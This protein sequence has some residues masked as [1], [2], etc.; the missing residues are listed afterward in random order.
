MTPKDASLVGDIKIKPELPSDHFATTCLI[1]IVRPAPTKQRVKVRRFRSVDITQL[2]QD[3]M[4]SPLITESETDI[5]LLTVQYDTVLG[6]LMD[7]H[8]PLKV[9]TRILRPHSP[10]YSDELRAK[11]A[12]TSALRK[13]VDCVRS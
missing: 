11:K 8:A 4:S 7:K 13:K 12:R 5:N 1:D 10:W 6:D 9:R 3:I 2:K